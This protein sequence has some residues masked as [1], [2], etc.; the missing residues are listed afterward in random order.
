MKPVITL[1]AVALGFALLVVSSVWG[2]L[3]PPT[4]TWTLQKA[5]RMSE[6]KVRINDVGAMLYKATQRI[7]AGSDPGP[8]QAEYNELTKE[9]DKLKSEFESATQRPQTTSTV[10]KWTGISLA[11]LGLVGWY[12]VKDS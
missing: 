6:V 5:E 10:L 1:G 4:Q 7:H 12:A 3:F 9:F 11:V 8:I 2:K